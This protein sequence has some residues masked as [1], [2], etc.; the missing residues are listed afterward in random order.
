MHA[1]YVSRGVEIISVATDD[2]PT[3][4]SA[5]IQSF[6]ERN[7]M[8]Q[9]VVRAVEAG[10]IYFPRQ[11]YPHACVIAPDG[12][13]VW[14]GHPAAINDP[15]GRGNAKIEDWLQKYAGGGAAGSAGA[16]GQGP[17]VDSSNPG[18]TIVY[19]MIGIGVLLGLAAAGL[20][21]KGKL[22]GG[23]GRNFA[24]VVASSYPMP[25]T[26]QAPYP[27]PQQYGAPQQPAGSPYG[28]PPVAPQAFGT[29]Q[30]PPTGYG[31]P[32]QMRF[33]TPSG[34][35]P[36]NAPAPQPGPYLGQQPA[37]YGQ[38][39]A[40][41]G[42]MAPPQGPYMGQQPQVQRQ[43]EQVPRPANPL[44]PNQPLYQPPPASAGYGG[45]GVRRPTEQVP[46]PGAAA[47]AKSPAQ[48][49]P[50][51]PPPPMPLKADAQGYVV[52]PACVVR[53]RANRASCM[54]CGAALPPVSA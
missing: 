45:P 35:A 38:P 27:P 32:G 41:G 23:G 42:Y 48:Q 46:R 10:I 16:V 53:T 39:Q 5:N 4:T 34:A 40:P 49:P 33:R 18:M 12:K 47:Y 37:A 52:C 17:A 8:T 21:L 19:A 43:T 9:I 22:G 31:A 44:Y 30:P 3:E 13:I 25:T 50:A 28:A 26:P 1:Q 20:M 51:P 24:P 54:N 15:L 29:V 36:M 14:D 11:G 7:S 2:G 6:I